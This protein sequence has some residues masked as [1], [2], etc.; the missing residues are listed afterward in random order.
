MH[1]PRLI[2]VCLLIV[3][4]ACL[5]M[6][7]FEWNVVPI[8]ALALFCGAHFRS[9]TLAISIPLLSMFLGDILL[10]LQTQNP[11]LYLFHDLM[12]FVYGCYVLSAAL[13]MGLR[14]YWDRLD[15]GLGHRGTDSKEGV[16][17]K[18]SGFWTRVVP[19]ASLT[20]AG[21]IVFFLVTNFGCWWL[22]NTYSKSWSGLLE[23]YL[24]A[25]PFFR[26]TLS[27]DLIGS[28]VLFGGEQL[29]R[30]DP[31]AVPESQRF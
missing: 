30:H 29:L 26:G 28:A 16:T 21:S 1:V 25:V 24:A 11:R 2:V 18:Y 12:P 20:V 23:C 22:F 31:M 17:R 13:G 6:L 10:A 27:G 8:A 7:T 5:R 14:R 9:R 3:A 15:E 19:I 4:P